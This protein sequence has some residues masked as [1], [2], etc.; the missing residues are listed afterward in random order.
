MADDTQARDSV[1]QARGRRILFALL[2][3]ALLP[4][5]IAWTLYLI[6][7]HPQRTSNY[8]ELVQPARP[9][10]DVGF[11]AADGAKR[12]LAAL[13]GKW[14]LLFLGPAVCPEGCRKTL[15]LL[16]QVVLA[17]GKEMDR[18]QRVFLAE[19]A[20]ERAAL[21]KLQSEFA[22]MEV[23]TGEAQGFEALRAQIAVPGEVAGRGYLV[24]P[25]G[26]LM[27]TYSPGFDASG[28]R[29]DLGRLLRI[30]RIG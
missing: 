24:D 26:N 9:L 12:S 29:K 15:Y 25:L 16:Q 7:W 28:M 23:W 4:V 20:V 14:T 21:S 10:S 5:A 30:S 6:N 13:R 17:Q 2:A 3:I 22:G 8:G 11:T 18:I 1:N 27:L 19:G